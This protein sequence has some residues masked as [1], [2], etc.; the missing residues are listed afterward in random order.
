MENPVLDKANTNIAQYL[1]RRGRYHEAEMLTMRGL[2]NSGKLLGPGH[3]DTLQ[4]MN[5]L[6]HIYQLQGQHDEAE[7]LF[8]RWDHIMQSLVASTTSPQNR[9]SMPINI[10]PPLI[11]L[12]QTLRR[13]IR[14]YPRK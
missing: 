10:S 7:T 9:S 3:P 14:C 8:G 4:T 6:A 2:V 5:N 12:F 13:L 11:R 1:W